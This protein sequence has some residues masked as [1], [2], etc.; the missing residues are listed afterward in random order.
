MDHVLLFE[1]YPM[2]RDSLRK[3]LSFLGYECIA[4]DSPLLIPSMVSESTLFA[5][6]EV[7]PLK[8][9]ILLSKLLPSIPDLPV[10][11]TTTQMP[12]W[13]SIKLR[14][15]H[16]R[17]RIISKP[18]PLSNL[19]EHINLLLTLPPI[20]IPDRTSEFKGSLPRNLLP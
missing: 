4:V 14:V 19:Q 2:V 1:S 15:C 8:P 10:L 9:E 3:T 16:S 20:E 18:F 11:L 13:V 5:I 17:C 12:E 6:V 7:H